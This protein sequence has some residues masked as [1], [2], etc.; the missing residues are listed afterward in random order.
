MHNKLQGFTQENTFFIFDFDHTMTCKTSASSYSLFRRSGLLWDE[1]E[2]K[3]WELYSYYHPFEIDNNLSQE[4][5]GKLMFEWHFGA[6]QVLQESW[7]TLKLFDEILNFVHLIEFRKGMKEFLKTADELNIPI[8]IFSAW[9]KQ[10]IEKF[11]EEEKVLFKNIH[12]Q[13]NTMLF[14]D[15]ENFIWVPREW[16]IYPTEKTW[17]K[18]D[19]QVRTSLSKKKKYVL[20]G[21]MID[22]I[23]MAPQGDEHSWFLIGMLNHNSIDTRTLYEDIFDVTICDEFSDEGLLEKLLFHLQK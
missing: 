3:N 23:T 22:D 9:I 15:F 21:D 7:L 11:L 8:V 16:F 13:T 1:F 6:F 17:D 19:A 12:I 10:V 18:I 2:K 20:V 14:D 5:R 4:E